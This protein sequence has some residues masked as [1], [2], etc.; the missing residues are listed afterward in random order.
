MPAK[1]GGKYL[2]QDGR[3]A[4]EIPLPAPAMGASQLLFA[5]INPGA[6]ARCTDAK[7]GDSRFNGFVLARKQPEWV[8]KTV[9]TVAA[10]SVRSGAP[11]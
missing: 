10:G 7:R 3:E 6:L 11:G 1:A 9:E 2:R 5:L 4:K 8:A